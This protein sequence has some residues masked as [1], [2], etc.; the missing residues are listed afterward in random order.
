MADRTFVASLTSTFTANLATVSTAVLAGFDDLSERNSHRRLSVLEE[1]NV[2]EI[3]LPGLGRD[4]VFR[5]ENSHVF[6]N[7]GLLP[8]ATTG[9]VIIVQLDDEGI[10]HF[11][12]KFTSSC[13]PYITNIQI[14]YILMIPATLGSDIF[15][16]C[17]D[18]L[19]SADCR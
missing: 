17:K 19:L 18:G 2:G 11:I 1:G 8:E 4:T 9:F 16:K 7:C 15:F 3:D 5:T 13:S 6:R 10:L 12:L 14:L